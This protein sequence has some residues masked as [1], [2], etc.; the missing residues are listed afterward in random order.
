MSY[1]FINRLVPIVIC[2]A[3]FQV[4]AQAQ[5]FAKPTWWVG[6]AAGAN[7]NDYRGTTQQL[8]SDLTIPAAFRQGNGVGLYLAPVVEFHRPTSRW[9]LALQIG[10]DSRQGSFKQI[11]TPCNC[12][13]ELS[14]NLSYITVEPSLRFAPFKSNLYLFTGPRLAFNLTSSFTY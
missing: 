10:Y 4:P 7:L 1:R 12:P 5:E 9:G 14:A 11:I 2:I 3:G 6:V 13:A 8:N